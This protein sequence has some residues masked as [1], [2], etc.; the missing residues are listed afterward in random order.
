MTSSCCWQARTTPPSTAPPR[1]VPTSSSDSMP[2]DARRT[3]PWTLHGSAAWGVTRLCREHSDGCR[4]PPHN[5]QHAPLFK[6]SICPS[7]GLVASL[8]HGFQPL[9]KMRLS[10]SD[11]ADTVEAVGRVQ[12]VRGR[13]A[14]VLRHAER[15][16]QPPQRLRPAVP[17]RRQGPRQVT[18][19]RA[20][21]PLTLPQ[22]CTTLAMLLDLRSALASGSANTVSD[23]RV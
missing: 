22:H 9:H 14:A 3:S 19:T 4:A 6:P 16:C 17:A 11:M 2:G 5:L 7:V 13:A 21:H 1:A 12:G 15:Q 23:S 18:R 20:P 10:A 8:L